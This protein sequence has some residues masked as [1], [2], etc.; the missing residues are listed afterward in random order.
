MQALLWGPFMTATIVL[1]GAPALGA[2]APA[3]PS[4]T[5]TSSVYISAEDIAATL[6]QSIKNNVVDQPI[7][8]MDITTPS[9]HR[10]SLA[11]LR[12]TKEESTAL[13]HERVTEIYQIVEGAGTIV[14]G[15]RLVDPKPSD[16]TRLNAGPSQTG[17]HQGGDSRRVGPKDVI[18]IPAG[19]A[20]RFSALDGPITYLV[21]RFEPK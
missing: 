10:A 14:T 13:I 20:H 18:I 19:T 3:A 15:G 2:Q 9:G 7:K 8:A 17:V 1:A 6:Q 12:R 11:L 4:S 21:Y 5:N 16:L